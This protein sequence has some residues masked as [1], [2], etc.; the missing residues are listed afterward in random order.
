M[1]LHKITLTNTCNFEWVR[2]SLFVAN[3]ITH[4]NNSPQTWFIVAPGATRTL[5]PAGLRHLGLWQLP[6]SN[7]SINASFYAKSPCYYDAGSQGGEI[8]ISDLYVPTEG[9]ITQGFANECG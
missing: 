7:W 4:G 8:V 1:L 5:G 9:T 6:F 3:D 2:S